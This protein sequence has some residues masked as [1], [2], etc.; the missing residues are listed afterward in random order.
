MVDELDNS[1]HP[2]VTRALVDLFHNPTTNPYNAQLIFTTHNTSLLD[3]NFLRR[4]QIWLT[5]ADHTGE[6]DLYSL[7]DFAAKKNEN[8]QKEYLSGRY[9]AVPFL[10][11]FKSPVASPLINQKTVA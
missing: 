10:E 1:L 3:P 6:T 4:D 8:F 5:S 7:Q 11:P 9:G 2:Y